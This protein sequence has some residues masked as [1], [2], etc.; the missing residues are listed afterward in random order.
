MKLARGL[1]HARPMTSYVDVTFRGIPKD[2]SVEASIHR[3]VARLEAMRIEIQ[4]AYITVEPSGRHRTMVSVTVLLTNGSMPTTTTVHVN[5]YVGVADAFRAVRHQVQ[6]PA[7]P[8]A[9]LAY[10]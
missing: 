8:R 9:K 3:W 4:R 1:H 6:A 10:A 2:P 7:A 5:T